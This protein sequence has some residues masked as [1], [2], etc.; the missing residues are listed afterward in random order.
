MKKRQ[1]TQKGKR[2]DIQ[3]NVRNR[4]EGQRSNK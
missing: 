2:L 3:K 1:E 4:Q